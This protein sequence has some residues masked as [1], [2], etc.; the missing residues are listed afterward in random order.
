MTTN[1]Q[2]RPED[3]AA[4]AYGLSGAEGWRRSEAA[5]SQYLGPVTE[6]MLDLADVGPGDRVLD[7]GAGTGEQT[8]M[9]AERVGVTGFVLATD[10]SAPMLA[11]AAERARESGLNNIQTKVTDARDIDLEPGS[12]DAAISRLALMLIPE[13]T[14][15]L[16]GIRRALK[17]GR[18]LAAI[19]LSTP[20]KNPVGALSTAVARR[21]AGLPQQHVEDPGIFALGTPGVIRA[22]F[23]QAG[24]QDVAIHVKPTVRRFASLE[25]AIQFRRD[26]GVEIAM[27][28]V[29]LSNVERD[30][31]WAEIREIVRRFERPDGVVMEPGEYLIGVGTAQEAHQPSAAYV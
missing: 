27:L 25:A 24:F 22:M 17:P 19:V 2:P 29:D 9:A 6:L 8:L 14:R 13:R 26:S 10:V 31:A 3:V 20:D 18:K 15:A 16:D 7:V 12:F 1:E 11:L 23:E 28:L 4:G 21:Y 5:R 30:R